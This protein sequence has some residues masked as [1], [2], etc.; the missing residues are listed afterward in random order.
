MTARSP[1]Q[2]RRRG[3]STPSRSCSTCCGITSNACSPGNRRGPA[4][5]VSHE[6]RLRGNAESLRGGGV[7]RRAGLFREY[8][9]DEAAA[10][11]AAAG[12]RSRGRQ[13]RGGECPGEGA[14]LRADPPAVL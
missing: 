9:A 11:P 1:V 6:K 7:Y 5:R 12:G 10:P 14:R 8:F 2:A 13:D 4:N 3:K